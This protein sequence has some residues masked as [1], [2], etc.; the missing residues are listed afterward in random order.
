MVNFGTKCVDP[1]LNKTTPLPSPP[2]STYL[3]AQHPDPSEPRDLLRVLAHLDS[4][5]PSAV[6]PPEKTPS[7]A[8]SQDS[9]LLDTNALNATASA[10]EHPSM[11]TPAV[12]LCVER[13]RHAQLLFAPNVV[14]SIGTSIYSACTHALHL[15]YVMSKVYSMIN[16]RLFSE[17]YIKIELPISDTKEHSANTVH[18][19]G[20]NDIVK[21]ESWQML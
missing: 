20:Q 5:R 16:H 7:P 9:R 6:T 17:K 4:A 14:K 2:L 12:M 11:P 18:M 15:Q 1:T 10:P 8:S 3:P 21:A 19:T 13:L